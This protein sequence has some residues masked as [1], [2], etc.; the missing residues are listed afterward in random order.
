MCNKDLSAS[1]RYVLVHV[2]LSGTFPPSEDSKGNI[3]LLRAA[4]LALQRKLRGVEDIFL[5]ISVHGVAQKNC[6]AMLKSYG[7]PAFELMLIGEEG[8]QA[9]L[10]PDPEELESNAKSYVAW[11]LAE[12]HPAAIAHA[13]CLYDATDFWWVGIEASPRDP[14]GE[15]FL[16]A[17]FA[18][19]V[20]TSHTRVAG[21]WLAILEEVAGLD[22]IRCDGP[23]ELGQQR[24]A[25]WVAT[26]CEWLHGFEAACGNSYNLFEPDSLIRDFNILRF[27]LGFEAARLSGESLDDL[28]YSHDEDL[29]G[30][31]GV[32]LKLVTENLRSELRSALADFFGNDS[33]LF[34]ALHS[35]V[36]PKFDQPMLEAINEVL[37]LEGIEDYGDL[38]T[39]W[40][41]VADGW[42]EE[43]DA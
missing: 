9:Q 35:T 34:W 17:E 20:P 24:S 22:E 13:E 23:E 1:L 21:T 18:R 7:F 5:F 27:F 29:D 28:C 2:S 6:E 15:A 14:F 3:D 8:S 26:L 40:R 31:A 37:N 41:F 43:A 19:H 39:P 25:V 11:W 33:G 36:W 12:K 10:I 4:N 42:C 38:E 16:G 30:I 32:A